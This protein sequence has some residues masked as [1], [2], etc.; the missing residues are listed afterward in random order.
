MAILNLIRPHSIT[1]KIEPKIHF[2]FIKRKVFNLQSMYQ[3]A[4]PKLL[5]QI[6]KMRCSKIKNT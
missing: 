1:Q 5:V 2:Y 4:L 6:R 3:R